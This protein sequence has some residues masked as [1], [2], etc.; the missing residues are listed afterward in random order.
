MYKEKELRK[1]A[2]K[3]IKTHNTMTI[4]TCLNDVPWATDVFYASEGFTLY[5]IS[6]PS[7]CIHCKNLALNPR[8]SVAISEDYRLKSMKDWRKI[9]G[10]Q[11]E[12]HAEILEKREDVLK[13]VRIYIK[14]YPFTSFYLKRLF[15]ISEYTFTEKLLMRL[16]ILPAFSPSSENR[17]YRV[18]PKRVYLVDN[19][20]SFEKRLEVPI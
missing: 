20:K 6:N 17:F 4:A 5:F 10:I 12:A 3:Y 19:E 8:I 9:K 15:D 11:M 7:V 18:I 2:L 16:K 13:A 14:K 1:I